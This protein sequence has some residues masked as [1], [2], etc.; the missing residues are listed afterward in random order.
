[1][2]RWSWKQWLAAVIGAVAVALV[3]GVPTGLLT[4]PLYTRMT[5]VPWWSYTVWIATA[6][7]SG[8]LIA[9]YVQRPQATPAAT[10]TG[11]VANV[12]SFLA[13]GCPVCNKVVI[14]LAG[15]GGALNVWA[16]MQPLIAA[17][18]LAALGWALRRRLTG[19]Q[20]CPLLVTSDSGPP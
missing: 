8:M 14:A 12:G 4:T 20:A 18:S 7:M 19:P 2:P 16:P 3:V 13:V 9:T 17:I 11:V 6:A 1:M 10:R 15:V 5:P